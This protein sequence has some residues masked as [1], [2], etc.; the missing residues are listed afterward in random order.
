M[1]IYTDGTWGW[2][3]RGTFCGVLLLAL[4]ALPSCEKNGDEKQSSSQVEQN[5]KRTKPPSKNETIAK[6]DPDGGPVTEEKTRELVGA[7][8]RAQNAGAFAD[9]EKLYAERMLGIKRVGTRETSFDRKGW[10]EDRKSMFARPFT[11][12]VNDLRRNACGDDS[13]GTISANV[14]QPALS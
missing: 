13:R 3:R 5:E 7:W 1:S 14:E 11:V 10:L 4:M 8:V 2:G 9:Y 6:Q 12:E